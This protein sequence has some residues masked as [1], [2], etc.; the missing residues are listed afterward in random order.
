[1]KPRVIHVEQAIGIVD[2][3]MTTRAVTDE[4]R[5]AWRV[6]RAELRRQL[7]PAEILHRRVAAVD[8]SAARSSDPRAVD[9]SDDD[10]PTRRERRPT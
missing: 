8:E 9:E 3:A 1:M 4:A 7:T 6:L 10:E 2:G 5:E